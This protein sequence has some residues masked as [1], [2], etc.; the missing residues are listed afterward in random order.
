MGSSPTSEEW[1]TSLLNSS[2]EMAPFEERIGC[3]GH[4]QDPRHVGEVA[5]QLPGSWETEAEQLTDS[6]ALAWGISSQSA[7]N[8]DQTASPLQRV[9]H[10]CPVQF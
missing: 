5:G 9:I 1:D 6:K 8:R 10:S 3:V 2:K 4:Y 7:Q